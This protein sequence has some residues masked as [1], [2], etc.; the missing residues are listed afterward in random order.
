M[1][2]RQRATSGVQKEIRRQ[3][4]LDTAWAQ[5]RTRPYAAILM[6]QIAEAAGL[7]KGT[8]YLY[9]PTKEALF[10]AVLE[11]Q[12]GDWFGVVNADLRALGVTR[13]DAVAELLSRTLADRPGLTHLLGLLHSVLETNVETERILAF[14]RMLLDQLGRTGVLLESALPPL[15]PGAGMRLLLWTHALIIGLGS[16]ADPPA[17]IREAQEAAAD[18]APFRIELAEELRATLTTLLE[19]LAG[20]PGGAESD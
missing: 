20:S 4:I 17:P 5:L 11:E 3:A 10:L 1:D 18:L 12:L 7:A 16:M 2:G 9:F 6:A 14:K 15:A 19:G 13:A 8:L